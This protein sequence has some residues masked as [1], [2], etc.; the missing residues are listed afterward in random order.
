MQIKQEKLINNIYRVVDEVNILIDFTNKRIKIVDF[1]NISMNTLYQIIK[2]AIENNIEKIICNCEE[3]YTSIFIG[4][5][6]IIEGKIKYYFRG[7]D[8]ICLSYFVDYERSINKYR[9]KENLIIKKCLE[10]EK[11]YRKNENDFIVRRA[12]NQDI[13][14]IISLFS[15]VFSTYPSPV[16]D[17]DFLEKSMNSNVLYKVAVKDGKILGIASAE[18]NIEH[19]NAEITDCA[20]YPKYRGLGVLSSIIDELE[21]ELKDRGILCLYSL[22]RAINPSINY[23]FKKHNYHFGGRLINNCNICGDFEDMNIWVKII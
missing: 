8:A 11:I 5:G 13:D 10:S 4:L 7:K 3:K 17:R 18:I 14:E 12:T 22:S 15:N 21:K 9:S 6:F 23:V 19:L 16:Y 20:T 1:S 2:I